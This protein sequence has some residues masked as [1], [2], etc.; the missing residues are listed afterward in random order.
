M[1]K[2]LLFTLVALLGFAS[3][4]AQV[5]T[6]SL[7]GTVKDAKGEPLIGATVKAVHGPT[8]TQYGASTNSEGRVSI[9][10]MRIGGPY[11]IRISFL[12]L[13][14]ESLSNAYLK[15]GEPFSFDVTLKGEGSELQEV[16]VTGKVDPLL[17]SRRTGAST[18]ISKEQLESLPSVGRSLSDFTRLTPQSSGSGYGFGGASYKYTNITVD[19]ATNTNLF[20]LSGPAPGAKAGAQPISLDAIQEVQVVLAPY[21][22][23]YGNFTGAGVNAVT[24]SGTNQV[25]GSAYFFLRNQDLE[26]KNP[27]TNKR[28][29]NFHQ[30]QYGVRVGG[31]LIENK[32]FYF[33]N[34]EQTKQDNPST[35]NV[36]DAG[37]A[38]SRTTADRIASIAN[39][40]GY[41]VGS[42]TGANPQSTNS[43]KLFARLDW[44]IND[45]H[46][47][48]VRH[49]YI[50]GYTDK[51]TRSATEFHFSNN[52]QSQ[53]STQNI[54]AIELRSAFSSGWSNNLIL[55][56][57]SIKDKAQTKGALSPMVTIN[58]IDGISGNRAVIGS[59]NNNVANELDQTI[60]E[61]TNNVKFLSGNHSF[62]FGTHNE[63]YKF[64]NLFM[65]NLYGNWTFNNID[66]FEA[67]KAL[68]MSSNYSLL[69]GGELPQARFGAGQLAFYAQ[70]EYTFSDRL[71]VTGGLRVDIPLIFDTPA[72]NADVEA[73]FPGQRTDRKAKSSL[74]FS[75]RV[76]FNYAA[77][78]ERSLQFRGGFGIFTGRVPFVWVGN[79]F[80]NAGTTQG[81]IS[82]SKP[83]A[84][85][86]DP[87]GQSAVTVGGQPQAGS[88]AKRA[89]INLIDEDFKFSQ[90]MRVNLASDFRLPGEITA[91]LEGIYSKTLNNILFQDL[92]IQQNGTLNPALTGGADN[93]PVF[94]AQVNDKF[95]NVMY[96]TNTDKGYTY[97]LTAQLQKAFA[98]GLNANFGYTY[99]QARDVTSGTGDVA[100]STWRF[101]QISG[102]PNNPG[103]AISS[104]EIRHRLVGGLNY[105]VNYGKDNLYGTTFSLFYSGFSG[106][107]F[108]YL[109]GNDLNGDTNNQS[110]NDLIFVPANSSQIKFSGDAAAQAAQWEALE[111]FINGDSYL[112]TRKG[113]YAERNGARTPWSHNFDLRILQ[114]VGTAF[115][116]TKNRLQISA[117]ISNVG[118]LLKK[119][120]GRQYFVS[121][122]AS[123]LISYNN[124]AYSFR[125]PTTG[126]AYQVDA[127]SSTWQMQ[128][129]IRYLFN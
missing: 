84:F 61:V 44:N 99:G 90:V 9:S 108:T 22:V 38:I 8:G 111:A 30:Y 121:N 23:V 62:T 80:T 115:G 129:G 109:Y 83:D 25:E 73:A 68:S 54:T 89:T 18:T 49:N 72:A 75:P 81:S 10:N 33:V 128:L 102:D 40:Y 48:M 120:W 57:T 123:S 47:L 28:Y 122:Q 74:M 32:L 125:A 2:F 4:K 69:P 5:T 96:L 94:K 119:T 71:K 93:R 101:N 87:Y 116:S 88:V 35:Y 7:T 37:A 31:P 17:N 24:R 113:D 51:L 29:D 110:G 56:H 65:S 3:V 52:G 46:Q 50:S 26:G 114:D 104:Y 60:F 97:S 12:G 58:N 34:A 92:N 42:Y 100:F 45:K 112:R 14:S 66:D 27:V 1:K 6:S 16:V 39:G 20:G 95:T 13:N 127:I 64:R 118:N 98:M 67:G 43:D 55:G 91:T 105:R 63:F 21:D 117:D 85:I 76:G 11:T 19:G 82:A 79:Q 53:K 59:Q 41:D 36:G 86:A 107:P 103:L 78:A 15:L 70:D 106:T 77:N 124:G 126:K